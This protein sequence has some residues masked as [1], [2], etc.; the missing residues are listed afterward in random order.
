MAIY[1]HAEEINYQLKEKK[2]VRNWIYRVIEIEGRETGDI[3]III[4]SDAFLLKI[5]NQY[6]KRNY[7]TDIITFDYCDGNNISGDIYLSI[8]RTRENARSLNIS[9]REEL[10]RVIIHGILHLTGYNDHTEKEKKLMTD[11]ENQYLDLYFS[12]KKTN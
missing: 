5:N 8:E 11:K 2:E 6:L 7:F 4:T 3:N 1:F 12:G 9:G 10:L